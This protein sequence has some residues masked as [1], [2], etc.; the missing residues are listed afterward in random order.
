MWE[1]RRKEAS[2]GSFIIVYVGNDE[3]KDVHDKKLAKILFKEIVS[4]IIKK[5]ENV[6]FT[7]S[8]SLKPFSIL[9]TKTNQ[10]SFTYYR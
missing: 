1:K 4:S 8:S 10:K 2:D 7:P 9:N 6:F 3:N 5:D